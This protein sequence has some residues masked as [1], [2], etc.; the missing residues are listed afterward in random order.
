MRHFAAVVAQAID[1]FI[2]WDVL[3]RFKDAGLEADFWA[4][5]PVRSFL[6][7]VDRLASF[8]IVLNNGAVIYHTWN[9]AASNVISPSLFQTHA[10]FTLDYLAIQAVVLYKVS[11]HEGRYYHQDRDIAMIA[12]RG[13]RILT[14]AVLSVQ[15]AGDNYISY[16][17]HAIQDRS[18][19]YV[20]YQVRKILTHARQR[21]CLGRPKHRACLLHC[22]TS[23]AWHGP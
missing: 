5:A 10:F 8:L 15:F 7:K 22:S 9:M 19:A 20:I 13:I 23:D 1:W 21:L 6:C 2:M 14:C 12:H 16:A 17:L 11:L 4:S 18:Q 3:L